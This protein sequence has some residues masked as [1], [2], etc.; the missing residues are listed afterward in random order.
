MRSATIF[1][2]LMAV[3]LSACSNPPQAR[4]KP[5]LADKVGQNCTS[6]SSEVTD[7]GPGGY[8]SAAKYRGHQ[9]RGG[10]HERQIA[11]GISRL[12]RGRVS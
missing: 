11:R 1:V 8:A 7:W 2:P 9:R 12:D 10:V 6:R 5:L 4:E 3:L